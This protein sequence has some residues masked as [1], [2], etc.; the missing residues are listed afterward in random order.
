MT[1]V[2]R[3]L[4]V[5][6]GFASTVAT[7]RFLGPEARG[8]YFFVVTVTLVVVQV[9]N[10]GLHASNTY[11]V[12]QDSDMLEPLV[13]NSI[14]SSVV[15]G[16]G[17]AAVAAIALG[18]TSTVATADPRLL[19]FAVLIAPASLFFMLGT[20]LLVGVRR[21]PAFNGFEILG[22]TLVIAALLV[23]GLAGSHAGGFLLAS[24]TAWTVTAV[25][26]ATYL[27]RLSRSRLRFHRSVF[28]AGL[29]YSLKSYAIATLGYL[30]LRGNVFLL[31]RYHGSVELGYYSVAAQ[32][33]DVI[34]IVPASF[35]VVLLP[36]LVASVSSSWRAM[37][38]VLGFVTLFL[39]VICVAAAIAAGPFMRI[40][41][42]R[43]FEPAA[44]L[45][46][47]LLPGV[48][49]LGMTSIIS[50]YIAAIGLP[51]TQVGIWAFTLVVVIVLGRVLIPAH[52]G[53]GAAAALSIAYV[54]LLGLVAATAYRLRHRGAAV[55]AASAESPS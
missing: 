33:A 23:A 45:L 7:A 31:Q 24:G 42:G 4:Q 49:A 9:A 8:E 30:V 52:G 32:A 17:A 1:L 26:L 25:L 43:D 15:L 34:A 53:A 19:W 35:A 40:A 37:I 22:N 13:G 48:F 29:R 2:A 55:A 11:R 47:L 21:I 5:V 44:Q 20:N 6:A 36:D 41:F 51:R 54:I 50:Q 16:A 28:V 27:V 10:L 18:A 12:A 46:R 38:R 39:V 3:S 14:W